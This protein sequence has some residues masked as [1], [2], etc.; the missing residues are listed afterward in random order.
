MT[1][2]MTFFYL[3]AGLVLYCGQLFGKINGP[4]NKIFIWRFV[5]TTQYT[6]EKQFMCR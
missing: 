1:L 2:R 3:R 4:A 5:A 6:D